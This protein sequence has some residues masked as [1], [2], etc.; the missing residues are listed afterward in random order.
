MVKTGSRGLNPLEPA[1]TDDF[2]PGHGHFGMAAENVG[3]QD[4]VSDAFLAGIDDFMP[5]RDGANLLQVSR[6]VL[7]A[8]DDAHRRVQGS[9]FRVQ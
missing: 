5:R 9:G 4:L 1:A 3:F 7:K 8:K 6:L 2:R